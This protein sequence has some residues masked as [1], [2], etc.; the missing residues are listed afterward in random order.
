[1]SGQLPYLVSPVSV[2]TALKRIKSAATPEKVTGDF[3]KTKLQIKGG[4]G[5][6]LIP[7][8]KRVGL[9]HSDGTP[10]ALYKSFRNLTESEKAIA[11]ALKIGYKPLYEINEYA[12]DL[13]DTDL[14]G[15]IIQV[16]GLEKESRVVGLILSTFKNLRSFAN[17]DEPLI[18]KSQKVDTEVESP[19]AGLSKKQ[20]KHPAELGLSYTINLNLPATSDISVF[21]AIFKSLKEHLLKNE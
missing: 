21:N 1:M 11:E 17:F 14:K 20:N 5:A 13:P 4:T 16:T 2:A 6:A 12:H 19:S 7:F 8:F 15:A 18:E 3:V 10:S 9:I